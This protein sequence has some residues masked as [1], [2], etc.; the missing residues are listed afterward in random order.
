MIWTHNRSIP[1]KQGISSPVTLLTDVVAGLFSH[2]R[3]YLSTDDGHGWVQGDPPSV[4]RDGWYRWAKS[5]SVHCD[6]SNR[7][8]TTDTDDGWG[9]GHPSTPKTTSVRPFT[10]IKMSAPEEEGGQDYDDILGYPGD[11]SKD[12]DDTDPDETTETHL[13][14]GDSPM[15][16]AGAACG[17]S[18]VKGRDV[19]R[20]PNGR[21]C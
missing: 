10:G 5:Q 11:G 12:K 18:S 6:G 2:L 4:I 16:D 15:D 9:V 1:G 8:R 17:Q 14:A 20:T 7:H 21:L 3:S 19:Q 13:D